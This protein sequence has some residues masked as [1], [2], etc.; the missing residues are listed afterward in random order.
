MPVARAVPQPNYAQMLLSAGQ[1]GMNFY[2]M[3]QQQKQQELLGQQ[4]QQQYTQQQQQ[5]KRQEADR[6]QKQEFGFALNLEGKPPEQQAPLIQQR[7]QYLNKIG[8][9]DEN[10]DQMYAMVTSGD[11]G[12]FQQAQQSIGGVIQSSL[13]SGLQRPGQK[14]SQIIL[15]AERLHPGDIRAQHEYVRK[16]RFK[17]SSVTHI[18]MG[19]KSEEQKALAKNRVAKL[20]QI[21]EKA[22]VA[23]NNIY[24]LDR[25]DA[26]DVSTGRATPMKQALAAWGKSFGIDT[27]RLANVAGGDAFTAE[28]GRVV[29]NVMAAQKGPQTESDMRQIRTTV[30]GLEKDPRA[31]K[32]INDS[33]RAMSRR[34]IEQ[35]DFHEN[36]LNQNKTLEGA[37]KA[38]N[39]YKRGTPMVSSKLKDPNGLPV[40]Y[41]RFYDRVRAANPGATDDE[42]LSSWKQIDLKK[43][44]EPKFNQQGLKKGR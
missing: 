10:L 37:S 31:N 16:A 24:S 28:A 1:T 18:S 39:D 4:R 43:G 7:M 20:G 17:P 29:L 27:S 36:Y 2:Q 9:P 41:F 35:R 42:I 15:E 5:Y 34:A 25:L 14:K 13:A 19:G 40:F 33:A 30:S 21:Q 22:E 8:Q 26:I 12:Q 11:P 6:Q 23:Q 44:Q 38:W 32:F 3:M